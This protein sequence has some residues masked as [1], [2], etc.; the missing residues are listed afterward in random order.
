[1]L[2]RQP[3]IPSPQ[4]KKL[5]IKRSKHPLRYVVKGLSVQLIMLNCCLQCQHPIL[6]ADVPYSS[7]SIQLLANVPEKTVEGGPSICSHTTCLGDP[8]AVPGSQLWLGPDLATGAIWRLNQRMEYFFFVCLAP[9]S[10]S[11]YLS[12]YVSSWKIAGQ[13]LL[14][15]REILRGQSRENK[16]KTEE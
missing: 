15:I 6:S 9:L 3:K 8:D 5:R 4:K 12:K 2:T 16:Y 13:I 14:E 1:M 10:L 11:F 7:V